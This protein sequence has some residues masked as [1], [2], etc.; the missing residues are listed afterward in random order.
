MDCRPATR[1]RSGWADR[2][3]SRCPDGDGEPDPGAPSRTPTATRTG[4]PRA[5]ASPTAATAS[6]TG[7]RRRTRLGRRRP[8][9]DCGGGLPEPPVGGGRRLRRLVAE[10]QDR[11]QHRQRG[12]QQ[13]QQPGDQDRP[14]AG[15]VVPARPGQRPQPGQPGPDPVDPVLL[16]VR[17]GRGALRRQAWPAGPRRAPARPRRP[18]PGSRR[19]RAPPRAR[20][21]RV[22]GDGVVV[23]GAVL[24]AEPAV[25]LAV[26]AAGEHGVDVHG[27]DD[28]GE[29]VAGGGVGRG[30]FGQQDHHR[31][32]VRRSSCA[33]NATP[34][35]G[36][37]PGVEPEVADPR[38][39]LGQQ[40]TE[41]HRS[42]ARLVGADPGARRPSAGAAT[43]RSPPTGGSAPPS[44][45]PSL[46][47]GRSAAVSRA[48]ARARQSLS[49]PLG[50][51]RPNTLDLDGVCEN[52]PTVRTRSTGVLRVS[53]PRTARSPP[54]ARAQR[55]P[56]RQ[57]R[58]R[59]PAGRP[60]L[61]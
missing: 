13:H 32:G 43:S 36:P 40:R 61:G 20:R 18:R 55:R 19:R 53:S 25:V 17:S 29:P 6:R 48:P 7:G 45:S 44:R 41:R 16:V 2:R 56:G 15:P 38:R 34:D 10:D 27:V 35:G 9:C 52:V 46:S 23:L 3:R 60:L 22:G 11:D 8:D 1:T 54:A 24:A 58:A 5:T 51:S 26:P 12:E 31:R 49:G 42:R 28:A 37:E 33:V 30:A 4:C 21:A 50:L 14:P 47:R 39:V 59:Q 57:S